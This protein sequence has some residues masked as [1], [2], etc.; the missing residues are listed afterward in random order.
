MLARLFGVF[1]VF[2]GVD[3]LHEAALVRGDHAAVAPGPHRARLRERRRRDRGRPGGAATRRRVAS[4]APSASRRCSPSSRRTSTWRSTPRT[5]STC[6]RLRSGRASLCRRRSSPGPGRPADGRRA[7]TGAALPRSPCVAVYALLGGDIDL[8]SDDKRNV[9]DHLD[10]RH[11]RPRRPRPASPRRRP[12]G[13][14]RRSPQSTPGATSPTT[15]TAAPFRIARACCL[16]ATGLLPR[17]HGGH[18]GIRRPRRQAPGDR[19]VRRDLLHPRPLRLVRRDRP[20]GVS[21]SGRPDHALAERI[22]ERPPR[23]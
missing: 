22:R 2:A 9:D 16:A 1:F 15:R 18:P 10:G 7:L 4:A 20:R 19:R 13:S 21:M 5:S 8:G 14:R 11:R 23:G 17:V 3:A 6:P 12:Q